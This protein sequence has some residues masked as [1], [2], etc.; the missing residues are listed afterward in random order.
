MT[1]RRQEIAEATA[2]LATTGTRARAVVVLGDAG[3]GKSWLVDLVAEDLAAEGIEV[4]VLDDVDTAEPAAVVERLQG[5]RGGGRVIVAGR[6]VPAEVRAVLDRS[7]ERRIV[8]LAPLTGAQARQVAAAHGHLE[9][10]MHT[11]EM[12]ES[13]GGNARELTDL[14][15]VPVSIDWGTDRTFER[16]A[17]HDRFDRWTRA[18]YDC[19]G[20][21]RRSVAEHAGDDAEGLAILAE[22]AALRG[23]LDASITLSEQ[24]VVAAADEQPSDEW[25]RHR[26]A[27]SGAYARA[28]LNDP[29]GLQSLHALAA[30]AERA[31]L[32]DVVALC[33][34]RIFN[35]HFARGHG[36]LALTACLR[37]IECADAHRV[38]HQSLVLRV[39]LA[40][41]VMADGDTDGAIAYLREVI[42]I[43]RERRIELA[44]L[45]GAPTLSRLLLERGELTES[46]M[47]AEEAL[48]RLPQGSHSLDRTNVSV[49]VARARSRGG[50]HAG[51]LAVL[52]TPQECAAHAEGSGQEFYLALE[53]IRIVAST[54]G[55][56]EEIDGWLAAIDAYPRDSFGGSVEAVLHEGKAW[57]AMLIGDEVLLARHAARAHALWSDAGCPEELDVMRPLLE[58]ASG[59]V[60]PGPAIGVAHLEPASAAAAQAAEERG[61][62]LSDL[63]EHGELTRREREIALLVA[64]GLTNPEIAAQLHLSPRTVEHHVASI[65]RK[66]EMPNRRALV[67]HARAAGGHG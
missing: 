52:G 13:A 16:V 22:E 19:D 32:G 7:F 14:M 20:A 38:L 66:L 4:I 1:V 3:I 24:A 31:G 21:A 49:T 18:V 15:Y 48:G 43:A 53:A 51:A 35:A 37:G 9:W 57:R 50:D 34:H 2:F 27:T 30:S 28:L 26:A 47:L 6:T 29:Y 44:F 11:A 62:A 46:R 59:V 17:C 56:P 54:G 33:W 5:A 60:R 12:V 8:V 25:L 45:Y 41:Q 10:G 65:L 36:E 58:R 23:D 55:A 67:H 64:G 42:D 40:E 39:L 61:D 63:P